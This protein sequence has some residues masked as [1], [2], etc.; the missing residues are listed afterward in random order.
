MV[1]PFGDNRPAVPSSASPVDPDRRRLK[2]PLGEMILAIIVVLAVHMS[3]PRRQKTL[4]WLAA[5]GG[6]ASRCG[7]FALARRT[8]SV[9]LTSASASSKTPLAICRLGF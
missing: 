4:P 3:I 8:L 1:A 7:Y 2:P 5:G 6:R 9:A